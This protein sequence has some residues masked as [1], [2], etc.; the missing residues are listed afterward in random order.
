ML[1]RISLFAF[2][3]AVSL[4]AQQ[5]SA[6]QMFEQS[7][8]VC[9]GADAGGTDRGPALMGNRRLRMRSPADIANTIRNGTPGGMP[10]FALPAAQV[11]TLADYVR[12]L[13]A[14]AFDTKPPG[15]AGA[16]ERCFFGAGGCSVCH[17]VAGRAGIHGSRSVERRSP[18]QTAAG[19][20]SR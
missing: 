18:V 14:N 15:D 11:T 19:R 20:A 4:P 8:G 12:S 16:G 6:R 1:K 3:T 13:N 17:S 7:C 5:N 10:G 2:V 9:H